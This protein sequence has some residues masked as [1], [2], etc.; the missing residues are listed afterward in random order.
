MELHGGSITVTSEGIGRGSC[1]TVEIPI[2][3]KEVR[4]IDDLGARLS[5]DET[6]RQDT[7]PSKNGC[8]E[9]FALRILRQLNLKVSVDPNNITASHGI[10]LPPSTLNPPQSKLNIMSLSPV[11]VKKSSPIHNS[12]AN[13]VH[14]AIDIDTNSNQTR[15][16]RSVNENEDNHI[17]PMKSRKFSRVLIVDDVAMNRK[18]LKRLF[19]TRFE[20]CDEA[21][22]G[23]QAVDMVKEA[24]ASG[25]NYDVITM[26]YQMPVMDGVTAT[27]N[28]RKLRF[29]GQIIAVTGNALSE[30]VSS[31][32]SNGANSVLT[33]PLSIEAFDKF[34]EAD[35]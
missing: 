21:E 17:M 19:V 30:D 14:I 35:V 13:Q 7:R 23:Q 26:D 12:I 15:I 11:D 8:A 33:K 10:S 5:A 24:M 6:S 18:M 31:F 22:D 9:L 3:S 1:F 28:I 27:R 20:E 2:T 29:H 32:L 4:S 34:L 25:I 16:Q